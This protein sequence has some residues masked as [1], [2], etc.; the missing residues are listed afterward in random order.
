MLKQVEKYKN[1]LHSP[2]FAKPNYGVAIKSKYDHIKSRAREQLVA[3][4]DW[5]QA[6]KF[7]RHFSVFSNRTDKKGFKIL[8]N[9]TGKEIDHEN[10]FFYNMTEEAKQ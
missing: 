7:K 5:V 9:R 6:L 8:L 1:N 3:S 2:F 10:L 4:R